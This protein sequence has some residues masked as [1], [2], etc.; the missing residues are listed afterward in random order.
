[1]GDPRIFRVC[2]LRTMR[3]LVL[4]WTAMNTYQFTQLLIQSVSGPAAGFLIRN[5][6][7]Y[8][9]AQVFFVFVTKLSPPSMLTVSDHSKRI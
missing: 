6:S 5:L 8:P 3:E 1:M 7:G 4:S 2:I 9:F